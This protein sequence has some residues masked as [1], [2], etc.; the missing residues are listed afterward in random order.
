MHVRNRELHAS[1]AMAVGY[2]GMYLFGVW[3]L[4]R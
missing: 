3:L 1:I 4:L 2:L